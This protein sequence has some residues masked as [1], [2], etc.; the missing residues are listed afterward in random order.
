MNLKKFVFNPFQENTYVLFDDTKECIIIDPGCSNR[1]EEQELVDYI[2]G[3]GLK[4]VRLVNTHCHLDHVYGNGFVAG[5]WNLSLEMH[6]DDLPLLEAATISAQMY[7]MPPPQAQPEP[8]VFLEAGQPL[9]FGE[10]SMEIRFAPG[11]APGHLIFIDHDTET[12]IAGDCLFQG[13][14]GRTDLPGGDYETLITS[15]RE[16]LY[17]LPD[18][19]VVYSGH[20]PK[21]EIGYEK[22]NNPFVQG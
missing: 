7:G 18:S 10:S 19:Y 16:Q 12:I 22:R 20:G 2:E 11:H 13:S 21:T 5:K 14:I 3:R 17:T 9:T 15:I 6:R 1:H 8:R 4:P